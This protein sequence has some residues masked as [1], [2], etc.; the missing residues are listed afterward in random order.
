MNLGE[1]WPF[2]VARMCYIIREKETN[3]I[4]SKNSS[5]LLLVYLVVIFGTLRVTLRYVLLVGYL[6]KGPTYNWH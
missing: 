6:V 4:F 5:L 1:C 3:I 2:V